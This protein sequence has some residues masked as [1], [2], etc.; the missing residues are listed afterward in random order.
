MGS[1][2]AA[3]HSFRDSHQSL[4]EMN[5][6]A[7]GLDTAL[8]GQSN[9]ISASHG[10]I[11]L[12]VDT[13][14]L[15]YCHLLNDLDSSCGIG[16]RRLLRLPRVLFRL[17]LLSVLFNC[18]VA[19]RSNLAGWYQKTNELGAI[20]HGQLDNSHVKNLREFA[21]IVIIPW[22]SRRGQVKFELVQLSE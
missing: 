7:R 17:F 8:L 2:A 11:G 10:L 13:V 6:L 20:V 15:D 5:S 4:D 18:Y 12:I 14:G 22:D 1:W 9:E 3:S 16:G 21:A 19:Q